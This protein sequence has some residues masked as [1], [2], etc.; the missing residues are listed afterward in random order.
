[1]RIFHI[2]TAADWRS[3]LVSHR[4]TTSTFGRTL[5]EEGFLH[6]ARHEQ[7]PAVFAERYRGVREPLVL[8]T[9]DTDKLDSPWR[10]EPVGA[11]TYPHIH[12]PLNPSAVVNVQ[13]LDKK[14]EP[15]GFTTVFAREM[16]ARVIPALL[17]MLV[18]AA[19]A[20]IGFSAGGDDGQRIGALVGLALGGAL[21][22]LLLRRRR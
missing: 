4:Y 5:A 14:G 18:T 12:G 22:V 2:A 20:G 16:F 11:T 1:M 19:G 3:A 13:P 10:E 21:F 9:I 6:A 8:L 15:L 7:L 17:A